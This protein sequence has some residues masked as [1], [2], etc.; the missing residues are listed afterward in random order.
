MSCAQLKNFIKIGPDIRRRNPSFTQ[1]SYPPSTCY[2]QLRSNKICFTLFIVGPSIVLAFWKSLKRNVMKTVMPKRTLWI[3][4]G[5]KLLFWKGKTDRQ[6]RVIPINY[7]ENKNIST[8]FVLEKR[9]KRKLNSKINEPSEIRW[10]VSEWK[11]STFLLNWTY[12][13]FSFSA[14]Q[15]VNRLEQEK[16]TFKWKMLFHT[17]CQANH[18][19]CCE[20]Q[21]LN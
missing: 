19:S 10:K 2:K 7:V 13:N 17:N 3:I 20:N 9:D 1:A 15:E 11:S 12:H 5:K 14:T 18:E 16:E 4:A 6:R 8:Y 21:Q